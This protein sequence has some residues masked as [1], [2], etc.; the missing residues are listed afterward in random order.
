MITILCSMSGLAVTA[1][2]VTVA[3]NAGTYNITP[4]NF[5][6]DVIVMDGF[7]DRVETGDPMLPQKTFDVL[8]PADVD[9]SSLQL[10][11]VSAK[12]QVLDG[13]YDIKPSPKWLPQDS[14][15]TATEIMI[16]ISTY[17]ANAYYP[18]KFVLLLPTSQMRKWKYVSVNFIPFQYNPVTKKLTLHEN[19][20]IEISYNLKELAPSRAASLADTVLDDVAATKFLNYNEMSGGYVSK[21]KAKLEPGTISVSDYVIITTNAI[22]SSSSKL[23]SFIA[24]KQNLGYDVLVVTED[25]FD[26]LTGQSP[27]NRAEKIRQW[28]MNNYISNGIKYVLLIGNPTPYENGGTDIPM[29]MCWPRRGT[30]SY[31]ECPTDYFYADLTGNWDKNGNGYYG[32]LVDYS[33]IGGVDLAADVYVGRIPVYGTDYTTLDSILQKIINYETSSDTEWRKSALLPM[34]FSDSKTDGAYLGEQM[35]TYYLTPN[36][37]T[38]WRMYQHGTSGSCTVNSVFSSEENL[39][40]GSVVPNR[41]A[42]SDFGI[43]SWWGHG[44]SQ[45]AYVGYESCSDGAFMLSSNAPSLDNAHPS[46]TYQCS[47][48]NGYPEY[49]SNLQ[50]AILKNGGITTTGATRVSWYYV[51][52]SSFAGSSSNAG[53][54]YEYMKRLVQ[55]LAA[56]DALYEMKSS[57]VYGPGGYTEVLMNFYDFCLY[58]DPSVGMENPISSPT[59]TNSIGAT[60]ITASY[61]RLNGEITDTGG[62]NPSVHVYWGDNDGDV[63][64][65]S[66]D[67][68]EN[69]G[70]LSSGTFYKDISGLAPEETYYYRC[71]ASN[72]A[73]SSW[74][75]STETFTS[76]S[77]A[78]YSVALMASNGQFFC[79]EGSGGGAVVANRAAIAA[80]ETFKLFDRGNGYY[81]LQ[82]ANGQYVCAEGGGG[83]AVVANR[84]A[85]TAWETFNLIDRGNGYFA[86]QAANGQYVCAEGSGGGAV[87][88]NRNAIGGWETFRFMDIRRPAKVALQAANGQ[89]VC[90]EGSGGGAVVANRDAIAV[91]ETFKLIDQGN[92]NV[93]LQ[94][95]N[96]QYVCAEGGGGGAVVANRNAIAAWETFRLI[97]RGNGNVALQAANGQYVCAEG[98][99][100]GAVVANRDAIG[101]WET[102]KF[103]PR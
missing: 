13:T 63:N 76:N 95:A 45:G 27:N 16:N 87:V 60:E 32:E 53:M 14:N 47:C 91:W 36:G 49:S 20:T 96:G 72:F 35:K 62:A 6:Y 28:L 66:W 15:E 42:N 26:G 43:V 23:S 25:D 11:I 51:G 93:A 21:E 71:F 29:K 61:A 52:Q 89:Y 70:T 34:S 79:A 2:N 12:K 48:T 97:Y 5:G 37:Y 99:G 41:W 22:E 88:A 1:G 77:V 82:A 80:W 59:I 58:G 39:R 8:L 55:G 30:G 94:A 4:D 17:E 103:I 86:L 102:F 44:N 10:K 40:G 50:Y 74:A 98:S 46:H 65:E 90:A 81:A 75:S 18:E 68:D 69:L 7:S 92:G 38:Y 19:V 67:N 24:H 78:F 101:A 84:N 9:D 85:I 83:G 54:G 64:S 57:G 100:G 56:G 3:L 31:E 73:G 33:T